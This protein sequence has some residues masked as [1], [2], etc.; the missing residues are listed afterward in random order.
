MTDTI[1]VTKIT[2]SNTECELAEGEQFQLSVT[3]SPSDASN[4]SIMWSSSNEFVATV[5]ANGLVTALNE[6]ACNVTACTTDG[7]NLRVSCLIR[8]TKANVLVES[9]T[10]DNTSLVIKVGESAVIDAT[11]MPSDA[12]NKVLTWSASTISYGPDLL[13]DPACN[14]DET[15]KITALATGYA[16]IR[17]TTTDGTNL[18]TSCFVTVID[19]S[20]LSENGKCATPT[21]AYDKGELIF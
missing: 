9:V 15:G 18:T 8:V 2:I 6:G 14:V 11:I 10:F 17:A 1:L 3:V 19:K 20:N 4:K 13:I 7:S 5:G 12:T 21:I 16:I